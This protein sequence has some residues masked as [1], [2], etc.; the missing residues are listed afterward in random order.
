MSKDEAQTNYLQKKKLHNKEKK[1]KYEL[2]TEGWRSTGRFFLG[3]QDLLS[4]NFCL[5]KLKLWNSYF[6][7]VKKK[8]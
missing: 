4:E 3:E 2:T 7:G 1:K 8:Q 5:L 6:I